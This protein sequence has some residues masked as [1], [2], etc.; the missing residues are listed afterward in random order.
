MSLYDITADYRE[1]FDNF[2]NAD[3]LTDEQI[4]AY[5]DTLEAIEGDFEIKAVNIAC[6][7]KEL[8]AEIELFKAE[9][10][11]L[12]ARR[13]TKENLE[14]RLKEMLVDGMTAIG[15]KKI[16]KP[17]ARLTLKA[18]PESADVGDE[19]EF[20]KWA[21]THDRDD[22]LNYGAPKVART[23]VKNAIHDGAELPDYVKLVRTT[24]VIIK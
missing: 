10:A 24:S 1:L 3:D 11:A 4:E 8:K 2:D 17:R 22:L 9:E 5:F 7:V 21:Q 6:Y 15:K 19:K 20:I 23:A 12:K 14:K 18:N 16:D 13:Q